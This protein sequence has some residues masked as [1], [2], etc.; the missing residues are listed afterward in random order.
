MFA[1]LA[2]ACLAGGA[3]HLA[4]AQTA[5][6]PTPSDDQVNAVARQIYSDNAPLD[7]CPTTQCAQWRELIRQQLA[8]G[9]TTAQIKDYF[10]R[11][12]GDQ[13]LPDPPARGFNWLIYILPAVAIL[14]GA[15]IVYL[16]LRGTH[17]AQPDTA[18]ESPSA[19]EQPDTYLARVEADLQKR[20]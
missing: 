13:V 9:W 2:A 3:Y 14:T 8:A 5:I 1:L 11:Y 15:Y 10:V 12:Y 20:K 18:P 7:L 19:I 6:A 4:Q 17:K 16:A